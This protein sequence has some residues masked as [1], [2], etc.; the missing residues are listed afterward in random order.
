MAT[1]LLSEKLNPSEKK[2]PPLPPDPAPIP[3][4]PDPAPI[5]FKTLAGQLNPTAAGLAASLEGGMISELLGN[6]RR[7]GR[8]TEKFRSRMNAV[9][10]AMATKWGANVPANASEVAGNDGESDMQQIF[11]NSPVSYTDSHPLPPP[12]PAKETWPVLIKASLI[13]LAILADTY[14]VAGL[15][16]NIQ[17]VSPPV[18]VVV[19]A[20]TPDPNPNPNPVP[21]P[22][23]N[24]SG[25]DV[26]IKVQ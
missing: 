21:T 13:A 10:D 16:Q 20:P 23:P 11:T 25:W 19:P 18:N 1:T 7:Q 2:S 5:P 15:I 17:P 6:L 26:Q 9:S 22:V 24:N 4:N 14:M 12:P 3:L 8:D